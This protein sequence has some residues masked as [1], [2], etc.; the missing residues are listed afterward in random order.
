VNGEAFKFLRRSRE[1]FFLYLHYM[2]P[3]SHYFAPAPFDRY[4]VDDGYSGPITGHHEELD[5]IVAGEL[6][7]DA[8][9]LAQMKALY[10]QTIRYFDTELGKLLQ[11]LRDSGRMDDTIIVLVA[12]H[13][14]ELLDHGSALHGYTLYE[15]QLRV[16]LLIRTPG[17][18][19]GVRVEATT[20]HV[21]LLPTL[22]EL[23]EVEPPVE[24]Q[25]RSLVP[26]MRDPALL[27]EEPPVYAQA[28]IQAFKTIQMRS[29]KADGWKLI[30]TLVPEHREELFHVAEDPDE[31]RNL[32]EE[33]P[34]VSARM[35]ALLDELVEAMPVGIAETVELTE[36]EIERLRSLGYVE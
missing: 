27:P 9:D 6:E 34:E 19:E 22:L 16:P 5:R 2:D 1:P 13:G 17:P 29:L 23:L 15:E 7:I 35:R 21:D 4:F 33:Q 36:E 28:S 12:D 25:G 11:Y 10:D 14:E 3:H 18:G 24:M 8:R 32:I 20:R 30:E 31:T 26:L